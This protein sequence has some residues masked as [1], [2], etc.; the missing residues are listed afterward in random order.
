MTQ[1]TRD[2]RERHGRKPTDQELDDFASTWTA[3]RL[4][5]LRQE[6]AS[7]LTAFAEEVV[8]DRKADILKEALRG[9]SV[10]SVLLSM[11]ANL[12]YTLPLVALAI[13]L[14]RAG[15]DLI[16]ILRTSAQH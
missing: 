13:V 2:R 12:F 9:S 16:G 7:V 8:E 10:R 4:D 1:G 14:A 6:A 3:D 15:V 11:V 5:G